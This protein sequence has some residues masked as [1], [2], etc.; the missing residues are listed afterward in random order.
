MRD[1]ISKLDELINETALN[2]ADPKGDYAA[3]SKTLQDLEKNKDVDPEA[4]K[5]R[6]LDLDKEARAKGFKEEFEVG[7]AFGISFST[8]WPDP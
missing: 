3:K 4:V 2:V 8:Y 1:L 7:D 6:K 5:Q